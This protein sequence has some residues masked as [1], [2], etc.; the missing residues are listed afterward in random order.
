MAPAAVH[1]IAS[2]SVVRAD[3]DARWEQFDDYAWLV[4]LAQRYKILVLSGD[5][6]ANR[7][8]STRLGEDRWLHDA[9]ASGAAV[10]KLVGVGS[11]CQNYGL[12]STD[13]ATLRL[14][15]YSHGTP[16]SVGSWAIDRNSWAATSA[17]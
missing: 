6:H 4:G 12:L 5:I 10:C 9:T 16:D 1:L 15:F 17:G 2:G 13:A 14:D 11:K 7:F 8:K 3:D